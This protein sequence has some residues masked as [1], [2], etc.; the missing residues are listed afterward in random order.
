MRASSSSSRSAER[1]GVLLV[2]QFERFVA[3]RSVAAAQSDERA[4]PALQGARDAPLRG[5][6]RRER[7]A[8]L[9]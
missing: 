8:Q 5:H 4:V 9:C 7:A 1:A 2:R 3:H 6:Q